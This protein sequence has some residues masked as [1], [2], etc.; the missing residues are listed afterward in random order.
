VVIRWRGSRPSTVVWP[1]LDDAVA[2]HGH[3]GATVVRWLDPE[4]EQ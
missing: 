4:P 3:N 2:V 1:N